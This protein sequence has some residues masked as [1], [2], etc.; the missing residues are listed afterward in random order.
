M[1]IQLPVFCFT[2]P[3][4]S[5]MQYESSKWF[6][7]HKQ[8]PNVWRLLFGQSHKFAFT[9]VCSQ[10]QT[11]YLMFIV[12]LWSSMPFQMHKQTEYVNENI[13]WNV[14][15]EWDRWLVECY[16][17]IRVTWP[18]RAIIVVF[19]FSYLLLVCRITLYVVRVFSI[20]IRHKRTISYFAS[21]DF[22]TIKH[23]MNIT[24]KFVAKCHSVIMK[25]YR[26]FHSHITASNAITND[27]AVHGSTAWYAK[28]CELISFCACVCDWTKQRRNCTGTGSR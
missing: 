13:K 7:F 24:E 9:F 1:L 15:R 20:D 25:W 14:D 28:V 10:Q 23:L 27:K 18:A 16:Q 2:L 17:S 8:K 21:N 26:T 22:V 19:P 6:V 3:F 11:D 12:M 5:S 4:R